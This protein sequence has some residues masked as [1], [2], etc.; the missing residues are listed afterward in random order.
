VSDIWQA[1][2]EGGAVAALLFMVLAFLRGTVMLTAAHDKE[3]A[4]LEAEIVKRDRRIDYWQ[5]L[6][7]DALGAN[8]RLVVVGH[9]AA[10]AAT[11]LAQQP[12]REEGSR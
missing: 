8:E 6:A 10:A 12:D 4:R 2:R 7:L 9:R 11:A 3:I 1:V 5:G